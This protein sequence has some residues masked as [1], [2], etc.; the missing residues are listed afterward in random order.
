V[1]LC[2]S[3]SSWRSLHTHRLHV[4]P[5][6][7]GLCGSRVGGGVMQQ[8]VRSRESFCC[9]P[10]SCCVRPSN[11]FQCIVSISRG[12]TAIGCD[13]AA[14]PTADDTTVSADVEGDPHEGDTHEEVAQRHLTRADT[15]DPGEKPL[16]ALPSRSRRHASRT[17]SSC[18][19]RSM[20]A[21]ATA[22][23][24][25]RTGRTSDHASRPVS[26]ALPVR[27]PCLAPTPPLY[28]ITSKGVPTARSASP[29][30]SHQSQ[31]VAVPMMTG[32]SPTASIIVANAR[33]S[34]VSA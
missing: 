31:V 11:R 24:L 14:S 20:S 7:N 5:W 17:L 3:D 29:C 8:S 32:S 12:S 13:A 22:A 23:V 6:R 15:S 18:A 9:R 16:P 1:R 26:A 19:T 2:P 25:S 34:G 21:V 10:C 28:A 30:R 33:T 27:T 4:V